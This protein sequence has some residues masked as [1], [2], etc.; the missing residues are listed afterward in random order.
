MG[1]ALDCD[2]NLHIHSSLCLLNFTDSDSI[3]YYFLW[4]TRLIDKQESKE[5]CIVL[6]TACRQVVLYMLKWGLISKINFIQIAS[7]QT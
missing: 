5:W 7:P 2:I 1:S 3:K 4:L 6:M